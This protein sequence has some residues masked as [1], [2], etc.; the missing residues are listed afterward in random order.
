V[1][2][3]ALIQ[4]VVAVLGHKHSRT[5]AALDNLPQLAEGGLG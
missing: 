3:D 1:G 4:A 2:G 5:C